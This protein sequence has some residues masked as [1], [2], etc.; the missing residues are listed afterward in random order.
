MLLIIP[1]LYEFKLMVYYKKPGTFHCI[2]LLSRP[3]QKL[4]PV[5]R[6][7][8]IYDYKLCISCVWDYRVFFL[9]E[10]DFNTA[11]LLGFSIYVSNT[12][13][14]D[15]GVLCFRDNNYTRATTPN[16]VNITCPYHGQYVIYY[17]N[18]TH[19]PFPDEYSKDAYNDLCEV[20]VY[21]MLN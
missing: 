6:T 3:L 21:G 19:P 7:L 4:K 18:R 1:K 8:H 13:N 5:E 11:Y 10:D 16:P 15:D 2:R 20:E 17:N 12:T 14:K 9:D